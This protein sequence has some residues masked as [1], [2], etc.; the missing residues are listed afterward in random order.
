MLYSVNEFCKYVKTDVAGF[1]S[2][3]N[4]NGRQLG[5]KEIPH[6]ESSYTAMSRV[7]TSAMKKNPEFGNVMIGSTNVLPEYRLPS[8]P[9][10]CDIVLLG[11]GEC[12]QQVVII[13]LK[14]WQ[15]NDQDRP[16]SKEGL[17]YHNGMDGHHPADQVKGY[18]EYCRAFHSA[19][20]DYN[21]D[22]DGCVFFSDKID[23]TPYKASPND[24]LTKDYPVFNT[25]E[26]DSLADYITDRIKEG[27]EQFAVSFENGYYMQNKQI[28][29]QVAQTLAKKSSTVRPFV[30]LDKQKEGF[31]KVMKQLDE[32]IHDGK[33]QVIIVEGPPGSGKSAVAINLWIEAVQRYIDVTKHERKNIVFV[34]TSSSQS[35]NWEE[36]FDLYGGRYGA[37]KLILKANSFNPG[38]SGSKMGDLW[39][40]LFSSLD[41]KY[42]LDAEKGKLRRDCYRE[43]TDYMVE[44]GYARNYKDNLHFLSIVDEA[45]ALI[46][47]SSPRFKA[48]KNGGWCYNMGPQAYHIIRES[49]VSVFLTDGKQA[50]RDI[51]TTTSADIER[52]AAEAGAEVTKV[53]LAGMQFRCAGSE[54]YVEWVDKLLTNHPSDNYRTWKDKLQMTIVDYPSDM[55]EFL[56]DKLKEGNTARILSS[57]TREWVSYTKSFKM[58]PIHQKDAPYDFVLEDKNRTL[59]K[60]HWNNASDYSV[61]I[62]AKEGSSMAEDPLC[63]VGCPYVVRGFDYD[64]IGLLWLE[65]LVW[66]KDRWVINAEYAVETAQISVRSEALKEQAKLRGLKASQKIFITSFDAINPDAPAST[67]FYESISQAYRILLTRAIKGMCIYV[68]DEETREHL[69]EL[70]K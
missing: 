45:H 20:A 66:R 28:L 42:V 8:T 46:D 19:I 48:N 60:R 30:L 62:Q 4:V 69:R 65:D 68:K 38:M 24:Q 52:I 53:S 1:V 7:F 5:A 17:I 47:P 37:N 35:N 67:A 13:E 23:T 3:M 59:F 39:F 51:E 27:D 25:K 29:K 14:D 33:K 61:F 63:E 31:L 50:F 15:P 21:A 11:K 49:Q 57:Y 6:L 26:I 64:Y 10:W 22:V 54:E 18:V 43:F 40:P 44:N 34:T 9:A 56:Q 41:E 12:R 55:D 58:L 70:L 2:E 16:G 36:I 32:R